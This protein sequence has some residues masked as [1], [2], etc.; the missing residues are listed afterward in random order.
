MMGELSRRLMVSNG[1]VTGLVERL[2][3]EGLVKRITDATDRRSA[4]VRLTRRGQAA[5]SRMA[6]AHR[7]WL[8]E[9]LGGLGGDA[10]EMLWTELGD[11][12]TT[13]RQS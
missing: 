3:R 12:K 8:S 10:R 7:N 11:L 9:L 6:T 1:N 13:V 5:F 4:R 2:S